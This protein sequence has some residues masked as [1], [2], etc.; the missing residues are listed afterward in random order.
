MLHKIC[1]FEYR[2][3]CIFVTYN[4]H[5]GTFQSFKI[6]VEWYQGKDV[7]RFQVVDSCMYR[8]FPVLVSVGLHENLKLERGK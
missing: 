6:N 4:C 8:L 5:W 7:A 1:G 3:S 2:G